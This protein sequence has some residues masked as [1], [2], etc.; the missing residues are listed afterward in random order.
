[1]KKLQKFLALDSDERYLLL[2]AFFLLNGIRLGFVLLEFSVLQK[3]LSKLGRPESHHDRCQSRSVS[4]IIWAVEVSTHFSPGGAKCLARA[5]AVQVLMQRQGYDPKLQIG[6]IKN[7]TQ[8]FRAHAWIEYQG[9]VVIGQ[10]PELEDYSALLPPQLYIPT[11][12]GRG[13]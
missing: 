6:V 1:M 10:L 4:R 9:M 13:Y 5:L 11:P 8:D 12:S 7:S 2:E 3:G